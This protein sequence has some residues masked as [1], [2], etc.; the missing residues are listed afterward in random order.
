MHRYQGSIDFYLV[1]PPEYR[2]E[3]QRIIWKE[4]VCNRKDVW[5][6]KRVPYTKIE[7]AFKKLVVQRN[8]FA[9]DRGF[10]SNIEYCLD[11]FK[12]PH[13]AYRHFLKNLDRVIAYCNSQTKRFKIDDPCFFD[14]FGGHCYLCLLRNFP[15]KNFDSVKKYLWRDNKYLRMFNPNVGIILDNFSLSDYDDKNN[16]FKLYIDKRQNTR[17]QITDMVH[18]YAHLISK[19]QSRGMDNQLENKGKY[20]NEFE[21]IKIELSIA[22]KISDNFYKSLFGEFLK[23]FHRV[24]FEIE[25]YNNPNQDLSKLYA[26]TFNKCYSGAK[27]RYNRSYILD[28]YILELPFITLPHAVSQVKIIE[29]EIQ[30]E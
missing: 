16:S 27:Q 14:E 22:R 13:P 6:K 26:L 19:L 9:I 29:S 25:V 2:K 21:A 15:F 24:L 4:P 18:E 7:S 11:L 3:L 30:K 8:N 1:Y 12:I 20:Y 23:V 17:H 10:K 28:D 5:N